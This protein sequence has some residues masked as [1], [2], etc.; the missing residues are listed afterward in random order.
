MTRRPQGREV[1]FQNADSDSSS[2][3]GCG[4]RNHLFPL[5]FLGHAGSAY[6]G[7]IKLSIYGFPNNVVEEGAACPDRS[8]HGGQGAR[9]GLHRQLSTSAPRG[10]AINIA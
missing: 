8:R 6:R 3:L 4:R 1:N 5:S 9:Q 7:G 2:L 10:A